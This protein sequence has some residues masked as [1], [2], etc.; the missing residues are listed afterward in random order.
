MEGRFKHLPF[1]RLIHIKQKNNYYFCQSYFK[2]Y[3]TFIIC[4]MRDFANSLFKGKQQKYLLTIA[5]LVVFVL[6]Y[7]LNAFYPIV[8]EDW[9]Y[10]LIWGIDE[11]TRVGN[12]LDVVAS[13]YHHYI[14]WGG[15]SVAHFIAQS[16]LIFNPVWHDIINTL[17]YVV[18]AFTIYKII[19][20]GHKSRSEIFLLTVLS[21]WF[22]L[23]E[24][25]S[26]TAWITYSAVYLWTTLL[27]VLFVYP[28]YKAYCNSTSTHSY[29]KSI[30]MFLFGI[31]A[32]WS[33]ENLSFML[34]VFLIAL[35]VVMKYRKR[36]IPNWMIFGL[37]GAIVGF[38][39]LIFAPGNFI[40]MNN[41]EFFILSRIKTMVLNYI[42]Y[43]II[44][45]IIY[46]SLAYFYY[47]KSTS[48]KKNDTLLISLL[49]F[50]SAH[51]GCLVMIAFPIFA[52]RSLFGPITFMIIS[53]GI[54]FANL[55]ISKKSYLRTNII[56][57]VVA[58]S[59]FI[60]DYYDKY[61]Y[62]VYFDDLW[63]RREVFLLG[64][65]S[66]GIM[67]ITYYEDLK[68]KEGFIL[69]DFKRFPDGWPNVDYA[70]YYG[71]DSVTLGY[72]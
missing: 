17:A 72:Q 4:F 51:L 53:A 12:L 49:F 18:F 59:I 54:L 57:L 19:N 38:A 37:I 46:I 34:I 40:R 56:L 1:F 42:Y 45:S 29:L 62:L 2:Y 5:V 66:K 65:K 52:A 63:H 31:I 48:N 3:K 16:L 27:T 55:P 39:F 13:Q 15:R 22:F 47:K 41:F 70:R 6:M 21:L 10:A 58:S 33:N 60:Y 43:L 28:Y 36:K 71:V 50:V 25:V 30:G 44:I 7:I 69:F 61:K 35:L 23:P 24:F 8:C 64:Q 68:F 20:Y 32:G 14:I 11:P 26:L 9:S 67:D